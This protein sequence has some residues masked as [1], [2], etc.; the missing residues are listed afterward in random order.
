MKA[1]IL[2]TLAILALAAG[3]VSW[4]YDQMSQQRFAQSQAP[5]ARG[6]AATGDSVTRD[7]SPTIY[8]DLAEK[9]AWHASGCGILAVLL[10]L[11]WFIS[12]S[13]RA[14]EQLT[15]LIA[16]LLGAIPPAGLLYL[17]LLHF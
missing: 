7:E 6:R 9:L 13:M 2:F 12:T 1:I 14:G 11:Y 8:R 10:G 16:M 4:H 17:G 15:L 3:A 5:K